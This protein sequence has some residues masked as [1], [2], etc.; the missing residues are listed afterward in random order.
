MT[1]ESISLEQGSIVSSGTLCVLR[2][3]KNKKQQQ[4][5]QRTKEDSN[6]SSAL[7]TFELWFQPSDI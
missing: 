6:V 7:F 4:E 2:A 5:I 3:V 1:V